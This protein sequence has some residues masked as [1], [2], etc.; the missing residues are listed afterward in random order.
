MDLADIPLQVGELEAMT[1]H[2][3]AAVEHFSQINSPVTV[4]RLIHLQSQW[5]RWKTASSVQ[6]LDQVLAARGIMLPECL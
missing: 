5:N 3:L 2:A 6:Q 1:A 4:K